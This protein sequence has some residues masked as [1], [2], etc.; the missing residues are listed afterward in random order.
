MPREPKPDPTAELAA[1]AAALAES[2]REIA[3][4]IKLMHNT[5]KALARSQALIATQAQRRSGSTM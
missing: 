3:Q 2:M 5:L 1:S 4:E